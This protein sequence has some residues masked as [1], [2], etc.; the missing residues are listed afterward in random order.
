M[1]ATNEPEARVLTLPTDIERRA[2][3]PDEPPPEHEDVTVYVLAY[4]TIYVDGNG[5]T[6]W[7]EAFSERP[8]HWS[9]PDWQI[10]H[11]VK[12]WMLKPPPPDAE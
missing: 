4:G 11:D 8:G 5:Y 12:G 2:M 7:W 3:P 10:I 1:E 6:D 9:R